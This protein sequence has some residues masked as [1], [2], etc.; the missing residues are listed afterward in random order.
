MGIEV[1]VVRR[2]LENHSM[3][4][5]GC[6]FLCGQGLVH[7]FSLLVFVISRCGK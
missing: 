7:Y 6:G 3:L 4:L 2:R 5:S 1:F